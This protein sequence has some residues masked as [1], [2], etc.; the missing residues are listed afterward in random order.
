MRVVVTTTLEDLAVQREGLA[1]FRELERKEANPATPELNKSLSGA[2][3]YAGKHLAIIERF[4]RFP[5]RNAML[6]R[7]STE[8]E[9]IFL[10][11]PGSSF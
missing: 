3:D 7:P 9:L 8:E 2:G 11:Q 4:G 10:T 1:L 6:G 5:H